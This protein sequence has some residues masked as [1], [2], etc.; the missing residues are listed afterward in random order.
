MEHFRHFK[1]MKE[2]VRIRTMEL[3]GFL[4]YCLT[5]KEMV[6]CAEILFT[7]SRGKIKARLSSVSIPG[8]L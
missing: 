7:K 6:A 5:V 1:S 2:M 4:E 8:N 3:V